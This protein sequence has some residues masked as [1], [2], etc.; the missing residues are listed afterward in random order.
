MKVVI[1]CGGLGTRLREETE[2]RPN[3]MVEIGGRPILCHNMKS[4]AHSDFREFV[5]SFRYRRDTIK[6]YFLNFEAVKNNFTIGLG[7]QSQIQYNGVHIQQDSS[8][9][10]RCRPDNHDGWGIATNTKIARRR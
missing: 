8:E 6:Q 1:L 3:S 9:A 4:Y 2:Y 5:L 10:V 7:R